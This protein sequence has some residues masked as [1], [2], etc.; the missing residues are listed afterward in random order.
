MQTKL[1]AR[2]LRNLAKLAGFEPDQYY[3][4]KEE[5]LLEMLKQK[6]SDIGKWTKEDA[7]KLL[8]EAKAK[9]KEKKEKIPA[10]PRNR[11]T[12]KKESVSKSKPS[13]E[14]KD[15]KDVS[16]ELPVR[17]RKKKTPVAITMQNSNS[18]KLNVLEERLITLEM[19]LNSLVTSI[20]DIS[21]FLAWYHNVRIDRSNKIAELEEI[22]WESAIKD[23]LD[24]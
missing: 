2:T 17:K 8:G 18:E 23:T 4:L 7:A 19:K 15:S 12:T 13:S 24:E 1:D 3:V 20:A 9:A 11:R 6:W 14:G 22:D 10:T 21:L 16:R 5:A